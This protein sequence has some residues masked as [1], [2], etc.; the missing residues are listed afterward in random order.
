MPKLKTHRGAAKRFRKTGGG[1][2]KCRRANRNHILTKHS[3]KKKRHLRVSGG[4]VALSDQ[5]SVKR[6]LAGS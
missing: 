5:K 1:S 3:T 6:L 4:V 2:F